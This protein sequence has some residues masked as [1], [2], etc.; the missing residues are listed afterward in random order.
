MKN[1][2]EN[3]KKLRR[4][5]AP[6]IIAL[7]FA[8]LSIRTFEFGFV[9]LFVCLISYTTIN[10]ERYKQITKWD[11]WILYIAIII[12]ILTSGVVLV[13]LI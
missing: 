8:I 4:P 9:S 3:S 11:R 1:V 6:S 2:N 5:Y 10:A 12:S 13:K 7:I